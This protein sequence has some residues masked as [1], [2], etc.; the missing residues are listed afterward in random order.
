MATESEV[1]KIIKDI[2]D[3]VD[4]N[5]LVAFGADS[6]IL[7]NLKKYNTIAVASFCNTS[8]AN[9][10]YSNIGDASNY[11]QIDNAIW[12]NPLESLSLRI[13]IQFADYTTGA[14]RSLIFK[15]DSYKLELDSSNKYSL[16]IYNGASD[17]VYLST[18]ANTLIDNSVYW[19]R[20]DWLYENGSGDSECTFYT[21][22]D[23]SDDSEDV[24]T[25]NTIEVVSTTQH[26]ISHSSNNIYI[27][28]AGSA[29]DTAAGKIFG[30]EIFGEGQRCLK[31][32]LESSAEINRF[33]NLMHD[34][35][36][37]TMKIVGKKNYF[38]QNT[39]SIVNYKYNEN[40]SNP[41]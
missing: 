28:S 5:T 14:N 39:N 4:E 38:V 33:D 32:S 11:I 37:N 1:Y 34:I 30:I 19:I 6:T 27:G 12:L 24:A 2:G 35:Y 18:N 41:I 25:W 40:W 8:L 17:I 15:D 13:K 10:I 20:A 22:A 36:D 31:F 21:S 3:Y 7:T 23:L 26:A 9:G 16:S 29:G